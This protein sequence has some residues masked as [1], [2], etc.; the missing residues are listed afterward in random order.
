MGLRGSQPQPLAK[1]MAFI[2]GGYLRQNLRKKFNSDFANYFVLKD[3]FIQ[4]FNGNCNGNYHGDLIRAYYYDAIVDAS[5]PKFA[6]QNEYFEQIRAINSFEVR[7]GRL[8]QSGNQDEEHLK[9]KGVDVLLAVDMVTMAYENHYEFALLLAG[10]NDFLDVVKVIKNKGKRVFG[11]YF[12]DHISKQLLN[13]L[14]ARIAIDNFVN[15]LVA[16]KK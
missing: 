2:D 16:K 1:I 11:F 12:R 15:P 14:D 13:I 4:E 7:L 5:H 8:I 10:D 9:Q 3:R 6:E